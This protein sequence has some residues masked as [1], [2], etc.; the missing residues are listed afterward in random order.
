MHETLT[1]ITTPSQS[2]HGSNGNEEV[3]HIPQSSSI[4]AS[5]SDDL[6]SYSGHSLGRE[7]S[8]PSAEVQLSYL[9]APV[10]R[11]AWEFKGECNCMSK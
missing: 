4:G 3:L 5:P 11:V 10:N 1:G 9:I 2:R 7:D 8:Y 6:V